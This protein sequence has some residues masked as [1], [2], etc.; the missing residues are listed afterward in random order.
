[1]KCE[2]YAKMIKE[3]GKLPQVSL[4]YKEGMSTIVIKKN[5]EVHFVTYIVL[6]E[7]KT[8]NLG[9]A[10]G[11]SGVSI[12]VTKGISYRFG[13]YKGQVKKED[14]LVQT[15]IGYLIITNKRI[16]LHPFPGHKP[17]S[18]PL[19]KVLSYNCFENGV[20]IFK[21]GREKG[22]FFKTEN[23]NALEIIGMCL[24]FLC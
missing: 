22:Y 24:G 2:Q 16:L 12:R 13:A 9:Y 18:I 7:M 4:K 23:P 8:I 6:M 20:E 5:E 19:N 11:S 10:G 15:S 3:N 21:D 14:K 17:I 1:M